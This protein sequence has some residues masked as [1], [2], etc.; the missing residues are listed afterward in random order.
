MPDLSKLVPFY[1]VQF[2]NFYL[3]SGTSIKKVFHIL[4]IILILECCLENLVDSDQL[5]SAEAS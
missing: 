5:A 2:R 1:L 4:L 3:L